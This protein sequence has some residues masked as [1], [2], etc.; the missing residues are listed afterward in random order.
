M[1]MAV[2]RE[3]TW[4]V[5][6]TTALL[7]QCS[8][9]APIGFTDTISGRVDFLSQTDS[10]YKRYLQATG[11]YLYNQFDLDTTQYLMVRYDG[12][13]LQHPFVYRNDLKE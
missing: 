3:G 12:H 7:K 2:R 4:I 5:G 6:L 13:W 8:P 10:T 9:F 1:I 11:T